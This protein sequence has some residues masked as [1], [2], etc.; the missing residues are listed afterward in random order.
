MTQSLSNPQETDPQKTAL[1]RTKP[2]RSLRKILLPLGLVAIAAGTAWYFL[3]RPADNDLQFSGRIEGYETDVGTK[4][5]GRV[6]EVTVREG[7]A[8]KK[9]QLL[10]KLD[11]DQV[12]AQLQ[13]AEAK[14]KAAQQQAENAKLQIN[15]LE[16]QV[17]EM[18]YRLQQ[19]QGDTSGRVSQ[20]E[21]QVATAEAQLEQARAQVTEAQSQLDLATADRDRF[22]QLVQEGAATQQRSDQANAAYLSA[23]A[24]L[25]SRQ[26]AVAAAQKQVT[27]AQG[28]LTQSQSTSFNPE[29]NTTQ[30]NRF[31]TQIQQA[32]AQLASAQ[33]DIANAEATRRQ[34]RSQVGDLTINSPIDGT[35]I[36]RS[37]EPGTVVSPG[38]VML[39]ILDM[40]T[41][42]MRGFI[43]EEDV[44]RVRVGQKAQVVLDS[45]A[46]RPLNAR[47][48]AIDTEASFTPENIYFKKDRVQ[49]VFGL[50]VAIDQPG[51]LAKPGMPAD[52]Q[53]LLEEK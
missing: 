4:A 35:V 7:A 36:S 49:Q 13:G 22:T 34:I 3:S 29:I 53:I 1:D 2:K 8:V 11:D 20:A 26:S 9:G 15:V 40:D 16:S 30:I 50:K 32:R 27:A 23:L 52:G 5:S 37:V 12:Q 51:G 47:V 42:Y 31:N 25:H 44:G 45:D 38:K 21:A 41:V 19:S 18:Q 48:I 39:T 43:P 10:V 14:L 17:T 46:D 24:T 28:G 33:A 6:E